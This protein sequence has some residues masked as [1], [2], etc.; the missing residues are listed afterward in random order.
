MSAKLMRRALAAAAPP[1]PGVEM[2]CGA[3]RWPSLCHHPTRSCDSGRSG[4]VSNGVPLKHVSDLVFQLPTLAP[5]MEMETLVM[6]R[7]S[8]ASLPKNVT[9]T[10]FRLLSAICSVRFVTSL[11]ALFVYVTGSSH[12]VMMPMTSTNVSSATVSSLSM[13]MKVKLPL[14]MA[15][16]PTGSSQ[17]STVEPRLRVIS[18]A[19]PVLLNATLE[20]LSVPPE[21]RNTLPTSRRS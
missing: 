13:G 18:K 8:G 6:R 3:M 12:C 1:P 21:M 15:S 17:R 7:G 16:A 2:L 10:L 14:G 11:P 5:L 20:G 4:L 9:S 19:W